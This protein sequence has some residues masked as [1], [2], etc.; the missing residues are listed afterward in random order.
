NYLKVEVTDAPDVHGLRLAA[1]DELHQAV[2]KRWQRRILDY[3]IERIRFYVTLR[4]NTRHYHTMSFDIA[5]H[6]LKQ[7]EA[8]MIQARQLRCADDIF[9]LTWDETRELERDIID[10]PTAE[11]L[12]RERRRRY[13]R[14]S[15]N[16][17]PSTI[18]I[19]LPANAP[20]RD[21]SALSGACACPGYAEG[22][23]RLIFDPTLGAD[24][25]PG[26][27]LV[28]PYTDPAWTP[29][30]PIAGAIVVEV[31]SYLSHAGTVAREYQVPCLVDVDGCTSRIRNGQRLKVFASDGRI[32]I[33]E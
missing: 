3:L 9:F 12:I 31:G 8:K 7:M 11:A 18:N 13:L 5:R 6:K 27:I 17:P 33:V 22:N 21:E 15:R 23:A 30:F 19:E 24:L 4:E 16:L 14:A 10:W 25:E 29:L 32:E 26:E 1:L 28:A 20:Q 2:P